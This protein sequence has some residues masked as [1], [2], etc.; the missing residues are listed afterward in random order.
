MAAKKKPADL[1]SYSG[2]FAARLRELREKAGLSVEDAA[3]A[4]GVSLR[5]YYSWESG[6]YAPPL[7][8]LPDLATTLNLKTVGGLFPPK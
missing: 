4:L 8:K 5:T 6:E 3:G 7:N 2:R 1:S